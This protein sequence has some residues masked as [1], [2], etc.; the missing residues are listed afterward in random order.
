MMATATE[1][2]PREVHSASETEGRVVLRDIDWAFYEA[3]VERVGDQHLRLTY[4]RGTLEIMSPSPRHERYMMFAGYFVDN[5]AMELDDIEAFEAYGET[6]WKRIALERGLEGDQCYY[7]DPAKLA[8]IDGRVPDRP[9]DP[10][11]DLAI[12]IEVS[13]SVLDKLSI[14][15][16]LGIPEVWRFDGEVVRFSLLGPDGAY[17]DA[18]ASRFLPVSPDE[19]ASRLARSV[20]MNPKPWTRQLRAWIRDEVAGRRRA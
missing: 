14:Y 7:F 9:D 4:D 12:E 2:P 18:D 19:V 10:L 15:A 20:S 6:T 8:A 5:L 13:D 1:S 3:L 16:A 17:H 11:P